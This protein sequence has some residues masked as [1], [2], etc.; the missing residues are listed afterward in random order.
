[1]EPPRCRLRRIV[2]R[3]SMRFVPPF[4]W[5]RALRPSFPEF[6]TERFRRPFRGDRD[7][8]LREPADMRSEECLRS[9]AVLLPALAEPGADGPLDPGFL[10]V[11]EP[12]Q[13]LERLVQ[14]PG[15]DETSE[16][17]RSDAS[18]PRVV[19]RRPPE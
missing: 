14:L 18:P 10:V 17:I 7:D 2:S 16:C 5:S 9:S 8:D 3:R 6:L 19:R 4:R 1:M 12:L 11:E 13:E 15:V